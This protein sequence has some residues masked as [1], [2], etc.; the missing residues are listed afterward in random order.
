MYW[1][2]PWLT[3]YNKRVQPCH[4]TNL[5]LI[6]AGLTNGTFPSILENV[7]RCRSGRIKLTHW[8]ILPWSATGK[9][10]VSGAPNPHHQPWPL[11]SRPCSK[12]G[13]QTHTQTGLPPSISS[14]SLEIQ[15]YSVYKAFYFYFF[16]LQ[17]TDRQVSVP[18]LHLCGIYYCCRSNGSPGHVI[19]VYV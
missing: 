10:S 2:G 1:A 18:P 3:N 11:L 19:A 12:A 8:Y 16:P 5:E 7:S 6:D 13:L 15:C 14:V 4:S 17:C 9:G